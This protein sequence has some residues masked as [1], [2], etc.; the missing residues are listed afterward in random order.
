[1]L[2]LLLVSIALFPRLPFK[3]APAFYTISAT[4]NK[5]DGHAVQKPVFVVRGI[6]SSFVVDHLSTRFE[7]VKMSTAATQSWDPTIKLE[8]M[9][10]CV[11]RMEYAVRGPLV[12]RATEIEK[13]IQSVSSDLFPLT[14]SLLKQAAP[15]Q[16]Y[17]FCGFC[18]LFSL[19]IVQQQSPR[20]HSC[21]VFA[22]RT[23]FYIAL[24]RINAKIGL[25]RQHN[26]K[27][28]WKTTETCTSP[29]QLKPISVRNQTSY[30]KNL[31]S[32]KT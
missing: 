20:R 25:A 16:S 11:K 10:P 3:A 23:N 18:K 14:P 24:L 28:V 1:M 17:R 31:I 5:H 9:N 12:I 32:R 6:R 27:L 13:E 22:N 4:H 8:N 19:L 15:V 21:F 2:L 26:W 7:S 30:L 29:T